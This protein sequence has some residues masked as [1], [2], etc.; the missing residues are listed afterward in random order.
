MIIGLNVTD[1]EEANNSTLDQ[2]V[3]VLRNMW[4]GTALR[5][6]RQD[7]WRLRA[8]LQDT[9]TLA[10]M[11]SGYKAHKTYTSRKV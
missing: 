4:S 1:L 3:K 11:V 7:K 9:L 6:V 5:T 8:A 10:N 2:V